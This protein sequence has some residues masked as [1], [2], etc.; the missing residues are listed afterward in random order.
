MSEVKRRIYVPKAIAYGADPKLKDHIRKVAK[1]L[2]LSETVIA[3]ALAEE[4]DSYYTANAGYHEADMFLDKLTKRNTHDELAAD[5]AEVIRDGIIDNKT[6][7]NDILHPTMRDVGPGNIR[8]AVAIQL[9]TEYFTKSP[10]N[11]LEL[12]QTYLSD[13]QFLVNDLANE[14]NGELT[15]TVSALALK[16]SLDYFKKNADPTYWQQLPQETRDG[17]LITGYNNGLKKIEEGRLRMIHTFGFYKPAPGGGTSGGLDHENNAA[18]LAA[19][20][21]VSNYGDKISHL[22]E[23][24]ASATIIAKAKQNDAEGQ[25][26]RYALLNFDPLAIPKR[27]HSPYNNNGELNLNNFSDQYLA[28]RA[29]AF[30][31]FMAYARGTATDRTTNSTIFQNTTVVDLT[32]NKELKFNGSTT[33]VIFGTT[34]NDQFSGGVAADRLYGGFGNDYIDGG[35]GADIIE[36]N[37]GNDILNGGT[38]DAANDVLNGGNGNDTYRFDANFGK[39]RII[40]SD[41]IGT[42]TFDGNTITETTGGGK[43]NFWLAKLGTSD[44]ATLNVYDDA[45]STTGK[46]LVITKGINTVTIN[47]FKLTQALSET[48]YLGIKLNPTHKTALVPGGGNNVFS[49]IHFDPSSLEGKSATIAEGTGKPFTLYLNQGAKEGDTFT[50]Q[51]GGDATNLKASIAGSIVAANGAVITLAEGQTQV[52]FALIQEGD[53]SADATVQLSARY[54]AAGQIGVA[55]SLGETV[56]SNSYSLTVKDTGGTTHALYH[57]D[58]SP[59][60]GP[61]STGYDDYWNQAGYREGGKTVADFS[62]FSEGRY[63]LSNKMEGLGGNDFLVGGRM[64]DTIDGGNGD[65][66]IGGGE[67]SD[68][69]LAGDGNDIIFGAS[70]V[71]FST[72][73]HEFDVNYRWAPPD[74][75]GRQGSP[76]ARNEGHAS[77]KLRI[78]KYK[79]LIS[80]N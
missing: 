16:K 45:Q 79:R 42:L 19:A 67:G 50:L 34:G 44:V 12:S 66:L 74:L 54:T 53:I 17:I 3:G 31:G 21:G 30:Q 15:V 47:N 10:E 55:T 69:L 4:A 1:K 39:D 80:I 29:N 62:D 72:G 60:V 63:N 70:Y 11:P 64:A 25:A 40:D 35:N 76:I 9:I 18:A 52:S 37:A 41:G 48:G 23:D 36:G 56:A 24:I 78:N 51:L 68:Q 71:F 14:E 58:Q 7:Q 49:D 13:Y 27:D 77:N 5:Y 61:L 57:G 28:D 6:K 2:E 46:R 73:E 20:L 26:Y 75:L 22:F 8:V 43:A 38:N 32:I 65:D 33:R 59:F